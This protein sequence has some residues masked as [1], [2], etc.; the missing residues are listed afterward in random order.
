MP[1]MLEKKTTINGALYSAKVVHKIYHSGF[2]ED[3][4]EE[5]TSN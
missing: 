3:R 2:A 4:S 1:Y 5:V